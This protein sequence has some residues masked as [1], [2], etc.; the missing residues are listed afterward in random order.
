MD[1]AKN[2]NKIKSK[3]KSKLNYIKVTP[4][5]SIYIYIGKKR[6]FFCENARKEDNSANSCNCRFSKRD[7]DKEAKL[8]DYSFKK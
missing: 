8:T 2:K 7:G 5:K 6:N 3:I 4:H 1:S